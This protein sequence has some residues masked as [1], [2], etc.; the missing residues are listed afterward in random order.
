MASNSFGE[1]LRITS[2]GES[3][4]LAMGGV[5]DGFPPGVIIDLDFVQQCLDRRKPGQSRLVSQR[6]EADKIEVL[7]GIFDNKTTGSPIAFIVRNSDQ[8]SADYD[9]LSNVYRPSHAD[10]TYHQKYG[11]VDQR[12]GGRASARETLV[13]V[14]AGAFATHLLKQF[15]I[16]VL[17]YTHQIGNITAQ[18]NLSALTQKIVDDSPTRCPDKVAASRMEELLA[19]L[20]RQGDSV[21]GVVACT[22]TGVPAGLG[23]PVY[24]KLSA[25][26]A[27][28]MMGINATKG[29]EVGEGFVAAS[30]KG[31]E[32]NDAFVVENG[33]IT[34]RTNHSGGIQGGISNGQSVI[35]RVA[36]KPPASIARQ[37]TTV[38]KSGKEVQLSVTGRHDPCVVPRAVPVVEAMAALVIADFYLR[39]LIYVPF[40]KENK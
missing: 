21:G 20:A 4:G 16:Q 32:H 37:Q 27:A 29:F 5:I 13:R 11:H 31:S 35:F 26:L 2:F 39:N 38:D 34:T 23:E 17:A 25:A 3:H 9:A 30:R 15:G 7:S 1:I 40:R 10:Y 19:E 6:K 18:A 28:A 33:A 8:R 14:A 12:G 24:N 36:F 22:I